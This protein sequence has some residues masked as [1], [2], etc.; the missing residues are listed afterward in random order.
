MVYYILSKFYLSLVN[1]FTPI[2]KV[3]FIVVP[4]YP[5]PGEYDFAK[6]L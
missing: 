3:G 5:I 4:S 6:L 2:E 1:P